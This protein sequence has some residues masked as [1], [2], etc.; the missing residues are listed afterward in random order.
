MKLLRAAGWTMIWAGVLIFAFLAYQ[1]F[2]TSI[3]TNR[4]QNEAEQQLETIFES[5]IEELEASGVPVPTDPPVSTDVAPTLFPEPI[6][7]AGQPFARIVIPSIEMD[8]VVWEGVEREDLKNGPGHMPWTA[9]PGQPGNAVI[10]GHR[11]TYGAPFFSLDELEVGDSITME[12]ATGSHVYEVRE[13]LIVDPTA[14]EVTEFRDGAWL[15]LTTCHPVYSAAQRLVIHAELVEGPNFDFV[16]Y[17]A[18][19]VEASS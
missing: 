13:I 11:T 1:L 8:H 4:A 3:G 10:S 12:T 18:E 9:L 15:T 19:S 6:P 14:V 17:Q 2:G 5:A 7:V 16:Q